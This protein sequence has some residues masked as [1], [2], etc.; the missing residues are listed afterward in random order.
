MDAPVEVRVVARDE[1]RR[2]LP[3]ERCIELMADALA[4]LSSGGADNP[5]RTV[6]RLPRLGAALGMMPAALDSPGTIGLKVISVFPGNR[7]SG[8]ESHQGFVLLFETDHGAPVALVDAGEITAIRT[9]AV[10]GLA[11]RLLARED[12][13]ELAI[14]GSGT[15]ARTHVEAI[16]VVRPGIRR[17][18]AWSPN[19]ERLQAFAAE[20]SRA[21]DLPVEGVA[22]A[23]DAVED[24]TIVCTVTASPTPVLEGEWLAPGVH[25]NAVGASQPSARELDAEAVRRS[26]LF[27]DR[28]ES[29]LHECGDLL[30]AVEAGVVEEGHIVGELGDLLTGMAVG[31]RDAGDITLF[32]SL[33]LAVEDLAA[34]HEVW[35]L[36][37]EQGVGT[38]IRL[39]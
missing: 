31:R 35:R 15:Q 8:Y 29:A 6:M 22:S 34:A 1:V 37:A 23:R 32:E 24:A 4:A 2:L 9:A 19:A 33:G 16:L 36:A 20:A 12:A 30:A 25:V 10:S 11:T 13:A 14:L 3:M 38:S 17:I 28:R 5:L 21:H 18:R 7:G 39:Q 26:R 27:V